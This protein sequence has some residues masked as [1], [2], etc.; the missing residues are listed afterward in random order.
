M[1]IMYVH[2]KTICNVVHHRVSGD[3]QVCHS[4]CA[5]VHLPAPLESIELL[6]LDT[7][8]HIPTVQDKP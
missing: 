6:C 5:Y 1:R 8:T 3:V 4:C 2:L 7:S